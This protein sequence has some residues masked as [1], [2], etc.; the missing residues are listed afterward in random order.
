MNHK[1]NCVIHCMFVAWTFSLAVRA[2]DLI[3]VC[4]YA[5]AFVVFS[6]VAYDEFTKRNDKA[7]KEEDEL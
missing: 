5:T 3:D 6:L 2:S 7:E 4:F 1:Q